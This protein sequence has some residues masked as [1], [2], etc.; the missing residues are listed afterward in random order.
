MSGFTAAPGRT[1]TGL[2]AD[3][4]SMSPT[5]ISGLPDPSVFLVG[6]FVSSSSGSPPKA[7]MLGPVRHSWREIVAELTID[8]WALR[9]DRR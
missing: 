1:S 8:R 2:D 3:P 4:G 9:Q 5:A 7:A 6:M